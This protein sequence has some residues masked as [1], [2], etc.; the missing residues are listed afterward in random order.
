MKFWLVIVIAIL[1]SSEARSQQ[2]ILQKEPVKSKLIDCFFHIYNADT[3]AFPDAAAVLEEM[4]PGHPANDLL[5]ALSIYWAKYP[6]DLNGRD[7]ERM[8]AL[9]STTIDKCHDILDVNDDDFEIKYLDMIAHAMTALNYSK[10]HQFFKAATEAKKAYN[11]FREGFEL[12]EEYNEFYFS[13]GLYDFYREKYPE[14][15]PIYKSIIWVFRSGDK[16]EG[17]RLLELAVEKTVFARPE[18]AHYSAHI[19]M[20]YEM[21]PERSLKYARL[22]TEEYPQNLFFRSNY[23]ENLLFIKEYDKA[24]QI[25]EDFPE[26]QHAYY[27]MAK[28]VFNAIISEDKFQYELAETL[29]NQA[30]EFSKLGVNEE[31]DNLKNLAYCGLARLSLL[32]NDQENAKA[33]YKLALED[34][35]FEIYKQEPMEFLELH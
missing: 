8:K 13:S 16:K 30:L 21:M 6:L 26:S 27:R 9:L 29:Y 15:Y 1:I 20:R 10:N 2:L 28:S 7:L 23:V 11:Y 4:I 5:K 24:A 34:V 12:M 17:L 35:K 25:M 22:L 18:A 14:T 19:L 33:Y 3:I 31:I 32:L